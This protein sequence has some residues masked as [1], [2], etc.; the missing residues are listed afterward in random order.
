MSPLDGA[1]ASARGGDSRTRPV[2]SRTVSGLD[3]NRA[4]WRSSGSA[5]SSARVLGR[6]LTVV[7]S[8]L[9][10]AFNAK[11][12]GARE[13]VYDAP[14]QRVAAT[15]APLTVL[16]DF[17]PGRGRTC[18]PSRRERPA[19][20]RPHGR[21]SPFVLFYQRPAADPF[22][23]RGAVYLG[24]RDFRDPSVPLWLHDA[25]ALPPALPRAR[26][27]GDA[28]RREAV[29]SS[30]HLRV[31][32]REV[33]NHLEKWCLAAAACVTHCG[34]DLGDGGFGVTAQALAAFVALAVDVGLHDRGWSAPPGPRRRA[35]VAPLLPVRRRSATS[36]IHLRSGPKPR[37]RRSACGASAQKEC[38]RRRPS[39]RKT[40][41]TRPSFHRKAKLL[42]RADPDGEAGRARVDRLG[43]SSE[44]APH[45]AP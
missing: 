24:R 1:R 33:R 36:A 25:E 37:S 18:R 2:R 23:R 27:F 31:T 4:A 45:A 10:D 26:R 19:P 12:T 7:T 38:A 35:A 28:F 32:Q 22:A 39:R 16:P 44:D 20:R 34:V 21:G 14:R 29:A 40:T 42:E 43:S 11:R 30:L 41:S 6:T 8:G 5:S 15:R 9:R 13:Q 17:Q 3:G